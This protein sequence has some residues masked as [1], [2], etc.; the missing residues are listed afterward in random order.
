M[1][2]ISFPLVPPIT[3]QLSVGAVAAAAPVALAAGM[4]DALPF[5]VAQAVPS[6]A[7]AP[8]AGAAET[9][10]DGA[11]MRPDQ[12]MMARQ[13]HFARSDAGTL[14]TSWRSMMRSY[15]A[16]LLRREQQPA[17]VLLPIMG[18][19]AAQDGRMQR[20]PDTAPVMPADAWRFTVHAGAAREQ[21]LSL[22]AEEADQA[23]GRRRRGRAALQLELE[24]EDGTRVV[25]QLAPLPGGVALE[26]CGN[27]AAALARLREL[28]PSLDQAVQRAGLQV[29]RW[30]FRDSLPAGPSHARLA[31]YE[32]ENVLTPSVFRAIAELAL[33]LPGKQ[34][35]AT[36]KEG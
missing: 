36:R 5:P 2:P 20:P 33:V 8:S 19:V 32:A 30:S 22:V 25:V 35:E 29:Q 28:Q 14:G 16:Q 21:H 31:A 13:L 7:P 34:E 4:A 6:A 3:P 9:A 18:L 10:T 24:L 15:G 17:G 26:L 1:N 12:L 23:P 27:G 11:A